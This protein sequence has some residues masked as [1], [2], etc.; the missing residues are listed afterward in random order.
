MMAI[1]RHPPLFACQLE[2][3]IE[4]LS[5]VRKVGP[6]PS[7]EWA[8][9]IAGESSGAGSGSG[10]GSDAGTR[11][12]WLRLPKDRSA[13]IPTALQLGFRGLGAVRPDRIAHVDRS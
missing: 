9:I 8:V 11:Q 2:R 12:L 1:A 7:K 3:T 13:L 4:E 6:W 5:V 10:S